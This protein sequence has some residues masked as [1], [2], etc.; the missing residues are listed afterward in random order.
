MS[1]H[2]KSETEKTLEGVI[3]LLLLAVTLPFVL[4]KMLNKKPTPF[5][6]VMVVLIWAL[7]AVLVLAILF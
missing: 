1:R 4:T 5:N 6:Q 3:T 2:R 7:Y